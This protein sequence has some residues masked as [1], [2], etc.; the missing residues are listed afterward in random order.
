MMYTISSKN[1]S[2]NDAA[3]TIR[4]YGGMMIPPHPCSP[5]LTD[6]IF[7]C[8]RLSKERCEIPSN[9]PADNV[10]DT[11]SI[12]YSGTNKSGIGSGRWFHY[13]D[14]NCNLHEVI[15]MNGATTQDAS[16]KG[17]LA[18]KWGLTNKFAAPPSNCP[19]FPQTA[20]METG[21]SFDLSM[22]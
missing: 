7:H 20:R 1:T 5:D 17:Y 11:G 8:F 4:G 15:V 16:L 6:D 12:T 13:W 22:H 18:Y 14:L 19:D 9:Q 3:F 2:G 21:K 10:A